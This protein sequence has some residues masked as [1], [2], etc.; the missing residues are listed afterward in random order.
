MYISRAL[1]GIISH[2]ARLGIYPFQNE[3]KIEISLSTS[4]NYSHRARLG[5][6]ERNS[7]NYHNRNILVAPSFLFL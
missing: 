1:L 7:E 3:K 2:R 4:Q 6:S 5:D